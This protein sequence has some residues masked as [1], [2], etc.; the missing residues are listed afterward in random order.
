MSLQIKLEA[1]TLEIYVS[2]TE[3]NIK[4]WI[5]ANLEAAPQNYLRK[6]IDIIFFLVWCELTP[7]VCPNILDTPCIF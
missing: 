1:N 5:W 7:E 2:L 4:D 6:Y 3:R